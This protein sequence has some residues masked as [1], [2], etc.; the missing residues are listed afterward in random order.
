[1]VYKTFYEIL[2]D[3]F[4][5]I[6]FME[7]SLNGEWQFREIQDQRIAEYLNLDDIQGKR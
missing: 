7:C 1:M 5:L 6:C 3:E 4:P 2:E